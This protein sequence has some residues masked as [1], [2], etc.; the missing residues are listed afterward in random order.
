MT[1]AKAKYKKSKR[2]ELKNTLIKF[3]KVMT[4]P[5]A[6]GFILYTL[7]TTAETGLELFI[8]KGMF[9]IY[10]V[11]MV[12]QM[13]V[14]FLT[15]VIYSAPKTPTRVTLNKNLGLVEYNKPKTDYSYMLVRDRLTQAFNE[16]EVGG[17]LLND[18]KFELDSILGQGVKVYDKFEFKSLR[19]EVFVKLRNANIKP[20]DYDYLMTV[21]EDLA[22]LEK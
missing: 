15:R 16:K 8:Y 12:I 3:L 20:N 6:F 1:N 2:K 11:P 4:I 18:F 9:Y 13:T 5:L 10:L 7:S 21:I 22:G 14:F 17:L 19:H